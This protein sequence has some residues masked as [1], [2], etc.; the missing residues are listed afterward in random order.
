MKKLIGILFIGLLFIPIANTSIKYIFKTKIKCEATYHSLEKNIKFTPLG[1]RYFV[2]DKK[3][4]WSN[5]NEINQVFDNKFK[6]IYYGEEEIKSERDIEGFYYITLD[7]I[8]GMGTIGKNIILEY[9][10]EIKYL[11][12]IK[13]KQKF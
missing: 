10:K 13:D 8:D 7:R 2:F 5:W 12:K 11:P 3:N 6:V 9:C 4:I 1:F